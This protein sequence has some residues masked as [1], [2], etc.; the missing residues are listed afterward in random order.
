MNN[1][2]I[3]IAHIDYVKKDTPPYYGLHETCSGSISYADFF[4]VKQIIQK[5]KYSYYEQLII[6][7]IHIK[8]YFLI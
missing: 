6:H 1:P 2:Y 3:G 4:K 8:N 7:N 5:H